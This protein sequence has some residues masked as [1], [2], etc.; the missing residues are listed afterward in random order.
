MDSSNYNEYRNFISSLSEDNFN[1]LVLSYI[2]EYYNTKDAYISNGPYDGGNDLIIAVDG[3]EIKR[4]IQITVQSKELPKKIIEDVIKAHD[5]VAQYV[6]ILA[7]WT[8]IVVIIFLEKKR[9]N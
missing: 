6:H 5:N 1:D 8:S 3:K 4:N 7:S 9:M 2:K